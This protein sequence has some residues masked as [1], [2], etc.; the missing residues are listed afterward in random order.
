[1]FKSWSKCATKYGNIYVRAG[2]VEIKEIKM[3]KDSKYIVEFKGKHP[4]DSLDEAIF[5]SEYNVGRVDYV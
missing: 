3:P 4:F 1:M 2:Y 5:F